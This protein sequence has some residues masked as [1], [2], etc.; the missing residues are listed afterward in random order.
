MH[1]K[2]DGI[3]NYLATQPS[4][5]VQ[6]YRK[7]DI[8]GCRYRTVTSDKK[9]QGSGV[10][11]VAD[12]ISM[13][14]DGRQLQ[15]ESIAY[16]GIIEQI[17][18]LDYHRCKVPLFRCRWVG[19]GKNQTTTEDGLTLVNFKKAI[20]NYNDPFIL[21]EH[22]SQVFYSSEGKD[23]WRVVMTAPPRG[24]CLDE[25]IIDDSTSQIDAS[26]LRYNYND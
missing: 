21:A 13:Q 1:D 25:D 18:E 8:N 19:N 12:T 24:K 5:K 3:H 15:Q 11:M 23:H 2:R 20:K 22:A 17:L 6:S 26:M 14:K 10:T 9:T 4:I 16:Y 7:Y